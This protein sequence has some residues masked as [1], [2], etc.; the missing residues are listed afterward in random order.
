MLLVCDTDWR[1]ESGNLLSQLVIEL[2][3]V[4]VLSHHDHQAAPLDPHCSS[5]ILPE[6]IKLVFTV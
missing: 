6:N 5:Q 1:W 2:L 4:L 3:I